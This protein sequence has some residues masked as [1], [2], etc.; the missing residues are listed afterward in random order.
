MP[1]LIILIC[2]TF[3]FSTTNGQVLFEK[4][5]QDQG[6]YAGYDIIPTHDNGYMVTGFCNPTNTFFGQDFLFLKVDS[7]GNSQWAAN[8]GNNSTDFSYSIVQTYD[9]GY[10]ACGVS[11]TAQNAS[12]DVYLIKTDVDG[13]LLWEKSWGTSEGDAAYD[14]VVTP[15][16]SGFAI[17][18]IKGNNPWLIKTDKFGDTLWSKSYSDSASL[19]SIIVT[20][21]GGFLMVGEAN[22]YLNTRGIAFKTNPTG[23]I[24]WI[25]YTGLGIGE[26]LNDC[27]ESAPGK[28]AVVGESLQDVSPPYVNAIVRFIDEGGNEIEYKTFGNE[29]AD[30]FNAITINSDLEYVLSG[31]TFVQNPTE[32]DQQIYIVKTDIDGNLIWQYTFGDSEPIDDYAYGV[33]SAS[34]G[35]YVICGTKAPPGEIYV[36]LIKIN[37]NGSAVKIEKVIQWANLSIYPNPFVEQATLSFDKPLENDALLKLFSADGKV[38]FSDKIQAGKKEYYLTYNNLSAGHYTLSIQSGKG[39][40]TRKVIIN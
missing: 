11:S 27:I 14:L 26:K 29:K 4:L 9:N 16:D 35:G 7:L 40:T 13:N 3:W 33:C 12:D 17:V 8:Y 38:V 20:S 18:G 22:G 37:D 32:Y 25:I 6:A 2:S 5:Y 1:K 28:F 23:V 30:G 21:D 39:I 10:A 24:E 15:A 34:D 19:K 31:N 36:Y